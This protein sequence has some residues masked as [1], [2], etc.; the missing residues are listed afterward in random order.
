MD[1]KILWNVV[2]LLNFFNRWDLRYFFGVNVL[3]FY[4]GMWGV[5]FVWY[6]EDVGCIL[7]KM[8]ELS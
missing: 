4:F 2:Y 1:E 8:G 6:V 3:Y 7:L 5:F